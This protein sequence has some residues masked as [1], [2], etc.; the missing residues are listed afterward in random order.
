M[1]KIFLSV[2]NRLSITKKCIEALVKHSKIPHQIHVY[3]NLTNYKLKNHFEYFYNLYKHGIISKVV[4]NS[5]ES[6]FSCFSKVVSCNQFANDHNMDPKKSKY[7]FITILDND[8]I[9]FPGWD[10]VIL[11]AWKYVK[12]KKLNN[13]KIISQYPGGIKNC[14]VLKDKIRNDKIRIGKLGGSA[15]WNVQSNFFKDVGLINVRTVQNQEKKHDINYWNLLNKSSRGNPYIMG[16]SFKLCV[17][18]GG[19]AGSICNTLSRNRNSKDKFERIKFK[20][21]EERIERMT[22]K[23]FFDNV[24]NLKI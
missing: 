14:E 20:D 16:L 6:T 11:D 10:E 12:K 8:I 5:Q 21:S 22:F 24:K 1:I 19:M 9:V 18:V 4:F 7:D 13:I 17:H 23:N 2:R 3:D 15:F